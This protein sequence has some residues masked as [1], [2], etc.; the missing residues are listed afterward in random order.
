MGW[1]EDTSK[2]PEPKMTGDGDK[3]VGRSN[4]N[5]Y[6]TSIPEEERPAQ[7]SWVGMEAKSFEDKGL[8]K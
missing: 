3:L 2:H 4:P 7:G 1:K 6:P 8:S 5:G